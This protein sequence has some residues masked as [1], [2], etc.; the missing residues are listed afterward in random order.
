MSALTSY[1]LFHAEHAMERRYAG[2][3]LDLVRSANVHGMRSYSPSP[4]IL[5]GLEQQPVCCAVSGTF[6]LPRN[7]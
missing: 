3:G 6:H 5:L 4:I 1:H 2:Q 7:N